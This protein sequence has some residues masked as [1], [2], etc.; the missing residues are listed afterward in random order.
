MFKVHISIVNGLI[1]P[2]IPGKTTLL[3]VEDD[4]EMEI[5]PWSKRDP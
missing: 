4:H 3:L 5:L 2:L 1:N